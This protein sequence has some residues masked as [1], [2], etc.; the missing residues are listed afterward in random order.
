MEEESESTRAQ[1]A[2][3][4]PITCGESPSAGWSVVYGSQISGGEAWVSPAN[5]SEVQL[6]PP[7]HYDSSVEAR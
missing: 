1:M 3:R 4:W 2:D 7:Q 6:S 5:S